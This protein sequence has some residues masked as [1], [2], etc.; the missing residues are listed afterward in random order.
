MFVIT[1]I[2]LV[3][4]T[5]SSLAQFGERTS[6]SC[7]ARR[8]REPSEQFNFDRYTGKEGYH[9]ICSTLVRSGRHVNIHAWNEVAS[10]SNTAVK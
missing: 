10:L 6:Y 4:D 7:F 8:P 3:G 1:G 5:Q 9:A 2:R